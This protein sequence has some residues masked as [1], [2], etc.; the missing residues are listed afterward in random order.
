MMVGA[1]EFSPKKKPIE[2]DKRRNKAKPKSVKVLIKL[3]D[4]S[5]T[6]KL[7]KPIDSYSKE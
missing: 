1:K 2:K 4:L 6:V 5:S 7:M 3:R